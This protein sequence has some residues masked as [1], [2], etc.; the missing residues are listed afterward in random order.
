MRMHPASE[1]RG[2]AMGMG[3]L[4]ASCVVFYKVGALRPFPGFILG[5]ILCNLAHT[6]GPTAV[7]LEQQMY[8]EEAH[9]QSGSCNSKRTSPVKIFSDGRVKFYLG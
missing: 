7:N 8:T 6:Q 3:A 9:R 5:G 2:L 4:G 1:T